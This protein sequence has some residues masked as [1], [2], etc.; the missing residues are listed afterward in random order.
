MTS[1][2][3]SSAIMNSMITAVEK[4]RLSSFVAEK[5]RFADPN[6]PKPTKQYITETYRSPTP[7]YT[8][9]DC[10]TFSKTLEHDSVLGMP[11]H[12]DVKKL[13]TAIEDPLKV[14]EIKLSPAA[15]RKLE[16]VNESAAF[17][18]RGTDSGNLAGEHEYFT[19]DSVEL[20]S[21]MIEVYA[22]AINRDVSFNALRNDPTSGVGINEF[23]ADLNSIN[24]TNKQFKVPSNSSITRSQVFRGTYVDENVGPY[25][26]Q[27]L[28]L[29][30]KYG[31][32]DVTQRHNVE[33]DAV[34]TID[35]GEWLKIQN[36]EARPPPNLSGEKHY[37]NNGRV[38]GTAVHSDPLYQFY[39]TAALIAAQNGVSVQTIP[40]SNTTVFS[41]GGIPNVFSSVADVSIG[42][43]RVAWYHKW[44]VGLTIRPE[45][46]A[47][48]YDLSHT[49]NSTEVSKIPILSLLKTNLDNSS[50]LPIYT[51]NNSNS[52]YL[53]LQY[54]EG[55]PTHP[56]TPA[57][58]AVVAGAACTVL[59]AMFDCH[60]TNGVKR[61]WPVTPKHSITGESLVNY[62][63]TDASSMTIVGEFNKLASNV[64]LGRD[65]AGVHYRMDGSLGMEL[66]ERYAITYLRDICLEIETAIH[67]FSGFILE[68]FNGT[69]IRITSSGESAV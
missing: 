10:W 23:L 7:P 47:Q 35:P 65:W 19:P 26:S 25:I 46:M 63:E 28:V 34:N 59:K 27:F 52:R 8:L 41:S 32:L 17:V 30:F 60:D 37:I 6:N 50:L 36:G 5:K 13:H 43:L 21:E 48:R 20:A 49:L 33:N 11:T 54:P 62:L 3:K 1:S 45:V 22:K 2:S 55:A 57:G 18:L 39:Y 51:A 16:G 64:S 12:E 38:L 42:A 58:H 31:S 69:I 68:K 67:N 4:I 40:H 24:F 53:K 44:D 56:S 29:P 14:S 66:G 9:Y 61:S 15:T